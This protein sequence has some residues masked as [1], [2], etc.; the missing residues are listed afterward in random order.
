MSLEK[1]IEAARTH[2]YDDARCT[3][4]ALEIRGDPPDA[5]DHP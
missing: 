4:H 5:P 3:P 1:T 2:R